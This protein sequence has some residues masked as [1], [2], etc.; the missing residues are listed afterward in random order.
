MSAPVRLILI[1]IAMTGVLSAMVAGHALQRAGG[2]E[3]RLEMTPVDPRDLLLGH[4]AILNTPL[5]TLELTGLTDMPEAFARGDVIFVS[6][7]PDEAGAWRAGGVHKRHPGEGV[8]MRG[9][10]YATRSLRPARFDRSV[11][12]PQADEREAEPRVQLTIRYNLERYYAAREEALA[13]ERLR[14]ESR[15]RLIVSVGASGDAVIKGLEIDGEDHLD[16]LF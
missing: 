7:V 1:A 6:L 11:T 2:T 13:L 8:V 5:H 3:V 4:Y 9:M 16:R 14:E 10:V 12:D 15:L